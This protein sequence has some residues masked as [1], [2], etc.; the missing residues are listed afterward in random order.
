MTSFLAINTEA[1]NAEASVAEKTSRRKH[2]EDQNNNK[3]N[4]KEETRQVD[5]GSSP[6]VKTLTAIG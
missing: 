4:N 1:P 6:Y 5:V 3:N 2:Q